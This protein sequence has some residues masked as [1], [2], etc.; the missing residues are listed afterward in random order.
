LR[1]CDVEFKSG[2]YG[3]PCRVDFRALLGLLS[4]WKPLTQGTFTH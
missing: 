3:L 2:Q 1:L 4:P